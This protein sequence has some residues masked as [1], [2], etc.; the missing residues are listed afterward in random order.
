MTGVQ[1]RKVRQMTESMVTYETA[2]DR[3]PCRR[4]AD[5]AFLFLDIGAALLLAFASLAAV[6][7]PRF[8]RRR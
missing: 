1:R 6:R 3:S 2:S 8:F 7:K 5:H 4:H